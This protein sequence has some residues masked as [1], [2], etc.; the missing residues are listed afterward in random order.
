AI[1]GVVTA[2]RVAELNRLGLRNA[3]TRLELTTRKTALGSGTGLDVI[4]AR[5][6]VET[7]RATL[8]SGDEALRQAREALG[9]AL[10]LPDQV[11]VPPN[12]DLNGLEASARA[13]CRASGSIDERADIA[14]L[15]GNVEIAE[16]MV[17]DVEY[18][19]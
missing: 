12:V 11:G 10:G 4:R 17:T 13:S 2:E 8:V 5:Q 6:D 9:L 7:A 1:V 15:R 3:L 19:F 14:A 16:R 18:Q